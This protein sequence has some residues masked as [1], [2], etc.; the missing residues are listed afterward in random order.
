[1]ASLLRWARS[2]V[3]VRRDPLSPLRFPLTGFDTIPQEVV[4]EEQLLDGFRAGL[5][6]PV[7]IGDVY[8]SKYQILGK[9]G[10]DPLPPC[11]MLGISSEHSLL[12]S[13]H[14]EQL[15]INMSGDHQHVAH[16][17]EVV[18]TLGPPPLDLLRRGGRSS[19]FFAEDAKFP[20]ELP[21]PY[22]ILPLTAVCQANE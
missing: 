15:E 20:L 1:M 21:S 22:P 16:L 6:Y 7:N 13:C 17:A 5:Y 2:L 9:L 11:G 3:A 14:G 8:A 10:L 12:C 18:G 19:E 4:V